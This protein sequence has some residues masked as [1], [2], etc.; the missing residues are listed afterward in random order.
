MAAKH[1]SFKDLIAYQKVFK[2]AM[3]IYEISKKFPKEER[4]SLTD[5]IRRN[6]KV[7]KL[8]DE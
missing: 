3:D 7:I 4:Y 6:W 1:T 5:Q 8:Y 2:L